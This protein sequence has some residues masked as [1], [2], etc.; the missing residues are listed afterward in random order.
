MEKKNLKWYEA[1]QME[2]VEMEMQGM[3]CLSTGLAEGE[4]E[5]GGEIEF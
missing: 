4:C 5:S 3:L 1:P 2:V